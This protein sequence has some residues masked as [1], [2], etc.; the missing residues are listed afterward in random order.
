MRI[1]IRTQLGTLFILS[2][3]ISVTVV[4]VALFVTLQNL[5][6]IL[7]A[8]RL[9]LTA[10]LK[11]T[12]V[13]T[14]LE[15][16][17]NTVQT[18]STRP[19]LREA[20]QGYN[21]GN[22]SDTLIETARTDFANALT[23]GQQQAT[24]LQVAI[25]AASGGSPILNVTA[26]GTFE[27][28]IPLPYNQADGSTI[29]LGQGP[30]G[31]SPALLPNITRLNDSPTVSINSRELDS[32]S[33][34]LLGPLYLNDSFALFSITRALNDANSTNVL[35]WIT[36]ILDGRSILSAVRSHVGL[37]RTGTSLVIAPYSVDNRFPPSPDGN[38]SLLSSGTRLFSNITE[39]NSL[40]VHRVLP[41]SQF[42]QGPRQHQGPA[43]APAAPPFKAASDQTLRMALGRN[44]STVNNAGGVTLL[45]NQAGAGISVGFA[46]VNTSLCDWIYQVEYSDTEIL[47]ASH[48]LT[49]AILICIFSTI[50]LM[51]CLVVPVTGLWSRPVIR[52]RN[53]TADSIRP[54]N[55]KSGTSTKSSVE[56]LIMDDE[57]NHTKIITTSS[58]VL[59]KTQVVAHGLGSR[60]RHDTTQ[61]NKSSK[62]FRIPGR[63]KERRCCV[64]DEM[65]DL[66]RVFNQMSEE[67]EKQYASLEERVKQ[68]TYELEV[69]KKAAESANES[70][71]L[72]IAN[73]SVSLP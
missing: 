59:E 40:V 33:S 43:D 47:A 72:F 13:G 70:K 17:D 53:A 55:L 29:W 30:Q 11:A 34:T 16:M 62:G 35:G 45:H 61:S 9:A 15:N 41:A 44:L 56:T 25:T 64:E 32:Q 7:R 18:L 67:L 54:A 52:L 58:G 36:V 19:W 51:L 65:T 57:L 14:S 21:A 23:G 5:V 20:L 24:A 6:L 66:T 37:S 1:S 50:A 46:L 3:L 8:Q 28:A 49:K 63:V 48:K 2:S 31:Y 69:S 71:S 26:R 27:P 68:R 12:Q 73:I 42:L 60:K 22:H 38:D 4:S 10:S 39:L